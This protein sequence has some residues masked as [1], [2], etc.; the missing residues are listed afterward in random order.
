MS[1]SNL[2][3]SIAALSLCVSAVAIYIHLPYVIAAVSGSGAIAA[4]PLAIFAVSVVVALASVAYLIK[5]AVSR[6]DNKK[7]AGLNGQEFGHTASQEPQKSA[8]KNCNNLDSE[9]IRK[10]LSVKQDSGSQTEVRSSEHVPN[11]TP[12]Q[13][14]LTLG[15]AIPQNNNAPPPPPPPPSSNGTSSSKNASSPSDPDVKPDMSAVFNKI[16][17]Q[18]P[19]LMSKEERDKKLKEQAAK[20][21]SN[22]GGGQQE[23]NED[24][25]ADLS[26]ALQ[27]RRAGVN[28]KQGSDVQQP[29]HL[30]RAF[31]KVLAMIPPPRSR[32]SSVS[33]D[34]SNVSDDENWE[35]DPE[36]IEQASSGSQS[37]HRERSGSLNSGIGS[38]S[39]PTSPSHSGVLNKPYASS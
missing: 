6:D 33:S 39:E 17:Q 18:K 24:L 2:K 10:G 38:G 21:S 16:T 13:P 23:K 30:G 3:I 14:P 34:S 22:K 7:E 26:K 9:L 20:K 11:L 31:S 32:S 4:V 1:T 25:M 12:Q 28:G 29:S 35:T 27:K 36:P 15:T 8:C 5:L 37:L 19:N